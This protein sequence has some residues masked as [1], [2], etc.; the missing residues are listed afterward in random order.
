M[1]QQAGW[2]FGG[3][4]RST[5]EFFMVRVPNR[6]AETLLPIIHKHIRPGSY[7]MSDKWKSYDD[8]QNQGFQHGSVCHKRNFV[9]PA[10]PNIHTQRIENAWRYAKEVYPD[11]STSE[12]LK[13]SYLQEYAYRKRY[14]KETV[15]HILHDIKDLYDW[16]KSL[17]SMT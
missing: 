12:S 4:C 5:I 9:D 7:I 10:D 8:L 13:D 11:R 14:G 15:H 2:V 3:I 6:K 16:S 1:D 17:Y